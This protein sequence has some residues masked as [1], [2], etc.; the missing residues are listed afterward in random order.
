[1]SSHPQRRLLVAGLAVFGTASALAALAGSPEQ[2]IAARVLLGVG[3][4]MVMPSTLSVLRNVFLDDRERAVAVGVWSAV[5][6][7]GFALGPIVGGAILEVAD[8]GWVFA[9]Q[10]PV[11]VAALVAVR[12][13]VPESRNPDPGPW[14]PVGVG[15][16]VGGMVALV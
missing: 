12:R 2:L 6:A 11:I 10:V 13:L 4:A 7:G 3:G 9:A 5:A 8:W 1:M 14:D 15:L 16:S